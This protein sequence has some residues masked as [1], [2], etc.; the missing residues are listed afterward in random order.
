[1]EGDKVTIALCVCVCLLLLLLMMPF[2]I[3]NSNSTGLLAANYNKP[4][5]HVA[6]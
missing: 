6:D 5:S 4:G 2:G 3:F 1:M